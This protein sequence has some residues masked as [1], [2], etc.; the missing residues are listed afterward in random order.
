MLE[1]LNDKPFLLLN[2]AFRECS[3]R[4]IP[5]SYNLL[6]GSKCS[7][8]VD[9]GDALSEVELRSL[10][11]FHTLL[12]PTKTKKKHT[13]NEKWREYTNTISGGK[14]VLPPMNKTCVLLYHIINVKE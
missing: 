12:H 11:V 9:V 13:H 5:T 3:R 2:T 14:H 8:L 4:A 7:D 10:L 1:P 6:V